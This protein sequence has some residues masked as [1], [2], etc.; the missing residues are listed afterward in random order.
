MNKKILKLI[1][2]KVRP[3]LNSHNGDIQ[4]L[5]I[6]DGIVR[7]RLL[8]QCV[9]CISAKDTVQNVVESTIRS[10]VPEIKK[11]ELVDFVSEDILNFAHKIL[12]KNV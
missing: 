5:E 9:N 8:G 4:V 7:I 11:V 1:N 12:S 2:E 10:E 3:Y 6:K